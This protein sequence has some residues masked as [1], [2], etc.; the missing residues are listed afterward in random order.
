MDY[1]KDDI[2]R[3]KVTADMSNREEERYC[4]NSQL[5]GNGRM[6]MIMRDK[7]LWNGDLHIVCSISTRNQYLEAL[8]VVV[9]GGIPN[10]ATR[11]FLNA[12]YC[13]T[14]AFNKL[15]C[16]AILPSS[17]CIQVLP[18]F[19]SKLFYTYIE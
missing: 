10:T 4:I 12:M 15:T 2:T 14:N 6:M 11:F 9:T 16:M 1:V 18:L 5:N 3:K 8:Q 7:N 19:S 13:D 17:S